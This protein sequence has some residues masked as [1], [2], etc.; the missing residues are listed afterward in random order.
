MKIVIPLFFLLAVIFSAAWVIAQENATVQQEPWLQEINVTGAHKIRVP[1]DM[2]VERQE[3]RITL[4]AGTTKND[5]ARIVYLTGELYQT[6]LNQKHKS[7]RRSFKKIG[8][9]MYKTIRLAETARRPRAES[10][11]RGV[12]RKN[13][14]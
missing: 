14:Y 5:E 9:E 4:E 11:G 6:I 13:N 10:R 1:K 7:C 12:Q 3:G 2:K 8:A